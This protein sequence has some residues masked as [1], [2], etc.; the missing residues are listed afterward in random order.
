M[1]TA[2][3]QK[4]LIELEHAATD[5]NQIK[6]VSRQLSMPG[7]L[8]RLE[9]LAVVIAA[10]TLYA[11][12][13]YRWW[14]LALLLLAPDLSMIGYAFGPRVGAISYNVVHAYI[15]PLALGIA[16]FLFGWP[17]ALQLALI[18]L[19]HIGIDRA[20]GY[21]LKYS[22]DFKHTHLQAVNLSITQ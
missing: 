6:Q 7:L 2:T 4:H 20:V 5:Q 9:G 13:D 21:G 12:N 1:S 3:N 15:L 14:V 11:V 18:W 8:L 17:L 10:M 22:D 19:L 16:G